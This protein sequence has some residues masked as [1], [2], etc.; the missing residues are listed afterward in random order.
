MISLENNK[1]ALYQWDL[2]QR[3]IID[4]FDPGTRVEF[5]VLYSD[6]TPLPVAAYEDGDIVYAP[7]PNILLQKSGYIRVCVRPAAGVNKG[8]QEKDIRVVKKEKPENYE[9]SE[10][11][12]LKT[13]EELLAAMKSDPVYAAMLHEVEQMNA[14]C[15]RYALLCNQI[16]QDCKRTLDEMRGNGQ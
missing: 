12:L 4:G 13:M 16:L 7:I 2:N 6:N 1:R 5:S 14:Q 3:V 10:T 9:Y 8:V 15:Q 11:P